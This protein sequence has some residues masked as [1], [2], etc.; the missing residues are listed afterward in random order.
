MMD[1]R[2]LACLEFYITEFGLI[3][4]VEQFKLK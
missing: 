2:F 1:L 4:A 3:L